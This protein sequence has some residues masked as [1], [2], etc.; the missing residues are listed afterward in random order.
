[1]TVYGER[2]SK[3]VGVSDKG[4]GGA[5]SNLNI[6]ALS[7]LSD[8]ITVTDDFNDVMTN[9]ELGAATGDAGVNVW[10]DC[11][12]VLTDD[13]GVSTAGD[14]IGM[15]D[16]GDVSEWAPS[17]IRFFPGT[18]DDS[19]GSMQL[20]MIN[21]DLLSGANHTTALSGRRPFP[22]L[23]IPE[24][25]AG[26]AVIDNTTWV[27]A[28]RVGF[29]PD[30]TGSNTEWEGKMF[31]GWAEA[32]DTSLLTHTDGAITITS[33]G[34]LVGFHIGEDASIRGISHRTVATAMAE[35]TNFTELVAATG[36][37]ASTAN[38]AVTAGD[39]IWYDFALRMNI[40]DMSDNS[41]NGA[42][43]FFYRPL[44]PVTGHGAGRDQFEVAAQGES[45]WIVHPTVLTN[46]T[47]NN[48]VALVPTIEVLNSSTS[49]EDCVVYIDSWTF[50]CSRFSRL[51]RAK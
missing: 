10:E 21:A 18:A 43:Q 20:D 47:P 9:T 40:T 32:G 41:A 17:C 45:P 3:T 5:A 4:M 37:D 30:I 23:W 44:F 19:G 26:A 27:F 50:A 13:A 34:P 14:Q 29:N 8:M 11:G 25:A 49:G 6:E 35:G 46:Q 38:G 36:V 31:I 24:T 22:H 48:D 2:H 1:M 42:T 7:P 16:A 12:W 15:N 33:G 39:T 51:P 28:C